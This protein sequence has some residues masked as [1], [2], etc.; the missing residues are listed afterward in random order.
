MQQQIRNKIK[1]LRKDAV[2]GSYGITSGLLQKLEDTVLQTLEIIFNMCSRDR[3]VVLVGRTIDLGDG[4]LGWGGM[5][6]GR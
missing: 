4:N 1:K 5:G 2:P 3:D 6:R